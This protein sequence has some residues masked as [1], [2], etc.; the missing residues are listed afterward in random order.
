MI[1][2]TQSKPF[3]QHHLLR[4]VG[5]FETKFSINVPNKPT[6]IFIMAAVGDGQY[7]LFRAGS[8]NRFSDRVFTMNSTIEDL[9]TECEVCA[10]YDDVTIVILDDKRW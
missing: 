5:L 6:D 9:L 8:Y 2:V 7:L 4:D 3:E 1:T 10:K